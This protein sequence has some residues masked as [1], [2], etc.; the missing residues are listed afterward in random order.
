VETFGATFD[1]IL[2]S[3]FHIKPP[4]SQIARDE[5]NDLLNS[6]SVEKIKS[7]LEKLGPSVEKSFLADRI[8]QLSKS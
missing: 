4:I 5:I 7:G 2:E 3:C 6:E 8:R 1:R